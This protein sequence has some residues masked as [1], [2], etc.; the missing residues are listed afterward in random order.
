MQGAGCRVQGVGDQ[1]ALGVAERLE[2][3]GLRIPVSGVCLLIFF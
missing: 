2:V 1:L 3:A